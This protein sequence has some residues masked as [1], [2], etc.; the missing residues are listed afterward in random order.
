MYK[1]LLDIEPEI[2]PVKESNHHLAD[3]TEETVISI[4]PLELATAALNQKE[5]GFFFNL[6]DR[7]VKYSDAYPIWTSILFN[8]SLINGVKFIS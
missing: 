8:L 3:V 4:A 6:I 2:E 5:A 7:R 1:S